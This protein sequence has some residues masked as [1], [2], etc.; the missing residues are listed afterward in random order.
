[1]TP[2]GG[3]LQ[4]EAPTRLYRC[5]QHVNETLRA[6]AAGIEHHREQRIIIE[7]RVVDR[8]RPRPRHVVVMLDGAFSGAAIDDM[9]ALIRI[10]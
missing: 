3:R 2:I 1:M 7:I 9:I 4:P 10:R 8:F 6:E 5:R